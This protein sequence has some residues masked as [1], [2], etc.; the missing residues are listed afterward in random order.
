MFNYTWEA[1]D[2]PTLFGMG[3]RCPSTSHEPLSQSKRWPGQNTPGKRTTGPRPVARGAA[4]CHGSAVVLPLNWPRLCFVLPWLRGSLMINCQHSPPGWW[5]IINAWWMLMVYQC[6]STI[7][8][9]ISTINEGINVHNSH[10]LVPLMQN[11]VTCD[12]AGHSRPAP[13]TTETHLT[14]TGEPQQVGCWSIL[15][16]W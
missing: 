16:Q 2:W 1:S 9:P 8:Q 10:H 13:A 6:S 14:V 5:F 11:C 15:K 3:Q 12:A 4:N 7:Y